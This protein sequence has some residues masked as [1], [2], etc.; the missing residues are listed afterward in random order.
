MLEVEHS[1]TT[2]VRHEVESTGLFLSG[3]PIEMLKPAVELWRRRNAIDAVEP[4]SGLSGP[5]A[6][7]RNPALRERGVTMV[8]CPVA[9][10]EVAMRNGEVMCFASF[11]DT[12]GVIE[13]VL[14]P[15]VYRAFRREL[16]RGYI[17][18]VHGDVSYEWRT[19]IVA[20]SKLEVVL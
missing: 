15:S 12:T 4:I 10:K 9:V 1:A 6:G 2:L 20:V 11:E 13:T 18:A 14:R 8:G 16:L 5:E 17:V 7:S 3:H 19:P